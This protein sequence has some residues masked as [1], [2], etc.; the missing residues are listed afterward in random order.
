MAKNS[1]FQFKQFRIEQTRA[2]MKV[3]TDGVLLGAWAN[4]DGASDI[5][6]VGTGTGLVALMLAQ[7]STARVDAV[8][9]HKGAA[10]DALDNFVNSQWCDRLTIYCDDFRTFQEHCNSRYD[11]I[12]SNPPFFVNSLKSADPNLAIARHTDT[13]SFEELITGSKNLLKADGRLAVIIPSDSFDEFR[14]SARLAGFYLHKLIRVIPKQGKPAKRALLEFSLLPGYPEISE[15]VVHK[16]L[17][18]YTDE[19][20][21][22]TRDFYLDL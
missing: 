14:E 6:D 9:L 16:N 1:W 20:I 3:G 8:E 4:T 10:A 22:L 17:H 18:D 5:L 19:F 13:L 2:P 7:R 21:E 15:L 12:V 11:L